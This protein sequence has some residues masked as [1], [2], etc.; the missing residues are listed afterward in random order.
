[1]AAANMMLSSWDKLRSFNILPFAYEHFLSKL[2]PAI[3]MEKF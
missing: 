3:D 1:M 2:S